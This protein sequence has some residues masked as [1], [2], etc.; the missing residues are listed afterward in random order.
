LSKALILSCFLLSSTVVCCECLFMVL[1]IEEASQSC[2]TCMKTLVIC[3]SCKIP[4][5]PCNAAL[6]HV[7]LA[8]HAPHHM[9]LVH[10]TICHHIPP[11]ILHMTC[12]H[13]QI[14][15]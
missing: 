8:L 9:L 11:Y 14:L 4:S 2:L 15:P 7:S 12:K 3:L 1:F 5:A 6:H 10:F 13:R